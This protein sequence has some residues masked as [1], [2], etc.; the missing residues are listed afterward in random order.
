MRAGLRSFPSGIGRGSFHTKNPQSVNT[1][2]VD[3]RVAGSWRHSDG[4][5]CIEPFEPLSAEVRQ[6]VDSEA[7]KIAALF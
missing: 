5:I 2:T 4:R 6:E 7:E 1:F 3:G